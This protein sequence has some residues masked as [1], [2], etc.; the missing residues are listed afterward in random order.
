[1]EKPLIEVAKVGVEGSNPF[2][3]SSDLLYKSL[4]RQGRS[5]RHHN[6]D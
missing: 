4:D 6:P 5:F 3:R 1:M 2:A